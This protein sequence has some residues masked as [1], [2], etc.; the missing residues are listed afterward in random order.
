MHD[1]KAASKCPC[2]ATS[3]FPK[4]DFR[5]VWWLP[6][7]K[8]LIPRIIIV[9]FDDCGGKDGKWARPMAKQPRNDLASVR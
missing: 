1:W 2:S 4:R 9:P 5:Q 3:Q 7:T 8:V 6:Q